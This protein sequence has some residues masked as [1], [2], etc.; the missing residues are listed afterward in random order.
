MPT[1]C[2][3]VLLCAGA[4]NLRSS[5]V[6]LMQSS[7]GR[8]QQLNALDDFR[9]E[10]AGG[11]LGR[12]FGENMKRHESLARKTVH[13]EFQRG[14]DYFNTLNKLKDS[15]DSNEGSLLGGRVS[16]NSPRTTGLYQPSMPMGSIPNEAS[17]NIRT[18]MAAADPFSGKPLLQADPHHPG[19]VLLTEH[20]LKRKEAYAQWLRAHPYRYTGLSTLGDLDA[21]RNPTATPVYDGGRYKLQK[22][23]VLV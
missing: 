13:S 9:A 11:H 6:A 4:M 7:E 18:T 3:V 19:Y 16:A 5:S 12:S 15:A 14:G 21:S 23:G 10:R 8:L 22:L 20:A 17:H 1:A 2:V